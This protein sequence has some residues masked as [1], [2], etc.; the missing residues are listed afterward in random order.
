[1]LKHNFNAI[2]KLKF[3][4]NKKILVIASGSNLY[5]YDKNF[6]FLYYESFYDY[7][8][9]YG[10]IYDVVFLN[11][12]ILAFVDWDGYVITFDT[13]TKKILQTKK[14]PTRLQAI[15]FIN[16]KLYVGGYDGYLYIFDKNL[17]LIKK[18][19]ID[20]GFET[21][22]IKHSKNYIALAGGNEGF[23]VLKNDKVIFQK[24]NFFSKAIAI[25]RDNIYVE[26]M[27]KFYIIS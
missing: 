15:D 17:K 10:S 19:F 11:N 7:N 2:N 1:M 26:I 20:L 3:S 24:N 13:K 22:H 14:L 6:K 18:I 25:N 12:N 5:F 23:A 21:L 8:K 4:P 16:N 27:R 9:K